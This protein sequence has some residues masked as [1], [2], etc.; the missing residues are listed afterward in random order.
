M[1]HILDAIRKAEKQ[2]QDELVPSLELMVHERRQRRRGRGRRWLL[3]PLLVAVL[4]VSWYLNRD[5]ADGWFEQ[6]AESAGQWFRQAESRVLGMLGGITE[7]PVEKDNGGAAANGDGG[8]TP[9][10]LSPAQRQL[11]Q[12][13]RFSVIS[14][15]TD[16]D[17]RFAMVGS[18]TLREGDLLEGFPITR[19]RK[20]G[21]MVDVNGRAVLIRP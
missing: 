10:A 5:L 17:K 18:E 19:I 11:L 9:T 1:S 14:F 20:D 12:Q 6:G 8:T 7:E 2:R 21:V 15:S 13:I 4:G 3:W 16:P